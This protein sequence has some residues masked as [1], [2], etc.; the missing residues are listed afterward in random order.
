MSPHMLLKAEEISNLPP[1]KPQILK[2][3]RINI[4]IVFLIGKINHNFEYF[5]LRHYISN[6]LEEMKVFHSRNRVLFVKHKIALN[7]GRA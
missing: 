3:S 5:K 4:T 2:I 1:K 6:G 7:L